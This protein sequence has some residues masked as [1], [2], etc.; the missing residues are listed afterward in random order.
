MQGCGSGP[1]SAGSGSW[2][3]VFEK[4]DPDPAYTHLESIQTCKFCSDQSDFIRNSMLI[5]LSEKMKKL[6]CKSYTF[7]MYYFI[8]VY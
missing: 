2:K 8:Y 4:P 7:V 3:S 5:F 6:A 1:F